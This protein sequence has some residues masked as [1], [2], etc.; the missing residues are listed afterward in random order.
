LELIDDVAQLIPFLGL[1]LSFALAEILVIIDSPLIFIW[2]CII[3]LIVHQ[4][5]VNFITLNLMGNSLSIHS[6]TII[7]VILAVGYIC[8][9]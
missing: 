3:P 7:V 8:G 9:F 5:E 4:L 6:L 1:W 2:V